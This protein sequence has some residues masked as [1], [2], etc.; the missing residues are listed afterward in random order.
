MDAAAIIDLARD[1]SHVN[2]TQFSDAQIVKYLNRVKD[3]FWS[4]LNSAN[5]EGYNYDIFTATTTVVNQSEYQLP[6]VAWDTAWI[7]KVYSIS[8]NYDWET[9]DT[10][11][12]KYLKAREV[13]PSSL[14]HDWNYYVN[15][16]SADDPIYYIADNSYFV[17]PAP[18]SAVTSWVQVKGTK[19]IADYTASTTEANIIIP[20]DHHEVLVQGILPYIYKAQWKLQESSFEKAEYER[21]RDLIVKELADRNLSPITLTYPDEINENTYTINLT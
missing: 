13:S 3:N 14:A 16:Q 15:N 19:K 18:Q 12:L 5:R 10:W 17:A 11:V 9:Y 2:S 21:Q 4:Y 8:I 1:Q 6:A 20:V 7:K